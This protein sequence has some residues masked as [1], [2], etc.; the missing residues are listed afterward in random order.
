MES[1]VEKLKHSRAKFTI[2]ATVKDLEHS[3]TH[4][5]EHAT[6]NVAIKGFRPGK[7]PKSMLIQ[8]IGKGRL[9]S[10]IVDHALPEFLQQAATKH[11]IPLIEAPA[12]TLDKLM[13]LKE[14]GSLKEGTE[15]IFTAEADYAPDVTVG[16]YSKIKIKPAKVEA[17]TDKVIDETLN[18]LADRRAAFTKVD[19]AAEKGDKV[20][21]D[22]AGKHKGIPQDR[23]A[24][25]NYPVVL[26]TGTMIPGFEDELIGKKAGQSFAFE[27][28]FPKD[29]HAK[30]LA[31]EKVVFDITV[32]SV[33]EKKLPEFDD[34]FAKQFG[35]K[36]LA[37]LKEAIKQD[38][39]LAHGEQAKQKDE[40]AVL[41]AFL[42]LVK[43]DLPE[44]LIER[45]LDRQM[46]QLR[47]QVK[48]IGADFGH[49]LQH[50]KKTEE[51]LR[52]ELRPQAEKAVKAGLGLG[53]VVKREKLT[54][55]KNA[56]FA[57]IEKLIEIAT[58]T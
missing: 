2:T 8:S 22:F 33:E 9:L 13:E 27:I 19:R 49:Y 30:D 18:E 58:R 17:V 25:K 34:A 54:N 12:Y 1:K 31:G 43:T 44:S 26:G 55:D 10:E 20:E 41:E 14:D 52:Q 15:L 11:T 38:R 5:L 40:E 24:S 47:D 46:D 36:T 3:V 45:E 42:P 51:E 23:L 37:E 16:D 57:A 32:H 48:S 35:Y 7:A 28:T 50:L 29:Y 56:G 21:I 39:E 6:A 53:E 4:V